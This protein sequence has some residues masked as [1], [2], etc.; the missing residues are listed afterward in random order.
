MTLFWYKYQHWT[1][2]RN[3]GSLWMVSSRTYL[4]RFHELGEAYADPMSACVSG[5]QSLTELPIVSLVSRESRDS[6]SWCSSQWAWSAI[7]RLE[8]SIGPAASSAY[9]PIAWTFWTVH[10]LCLTLR[11]FLM[12]W[13]Q[14][15]PVTRCTWDGC[16]VAF[17]FGAELV[18][19]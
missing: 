3:F 7:N 12:E 17:S 16:R 18:Q 14:R 5:A 2:E 8:T 1:N 6:G 13:A 10:R 9:T 15:S 19:G 4:L 11:A